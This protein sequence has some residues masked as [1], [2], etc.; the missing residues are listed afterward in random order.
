MPHE[1]PTR[2]HFLGGVALSAIAPPVI[3]T[4]KAAANPLASNEFEFEITRTEAEWQERLDSFEFN[5]LRQ[6]GTEPHFSSRLW[7]EERAGHYECRGCDLRLYESEWKTIRQIGWVFFYHSAPSSVM[8]GIDVLPP[9]DDP[10]TEEPRTMVEAHCRRCGSHLGHLVV[11]EGEL[12][13]CIN[14]ASL[15]FHPTA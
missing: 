8:T 15:V 10:E 4:S 1:N 3:L 9:D 11:V 7:N 14:G 5:I 2:R 6:G 12:L 13:H